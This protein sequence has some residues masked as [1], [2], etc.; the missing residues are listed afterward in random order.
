MD[1]S[2]FLSGFYSGSLPETF[3][4]L[5]GIKL[6]LLALAGIIAVYVLPKLPYWFDEKIDKI[7]VLDFD[8]NTKK[9]FS[10]IL[11]WGVYLAV[12]YLAFYIVGFTLIHRNPLFQLVLLF[13]GIKMAIAALKPSIKK[14]DKKINDVDVKKGSI[15]TKMLTISIYVIGLFIALSIFGLDGAITTALAGAGVIGLVIG[16]GAKD[17]V[18]NTLSGIFIAIDKPFQIGDMIEIKGEV[19]EVTDMGLRTTEIKKF[20]NKVVTIPNSSVA[21]NPVLNYTAEETRRVSLEVGIGYDSDMEEAISTIKTALSSLES[22]AS[23]QEP[24]VL[25]KEFG[26]SAIVME[27]RVW[28]NQEDY[29]VIT[30]TSKAKEAVLDALRE[31]EIN[32]PFPTRV[33]IKR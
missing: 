24:D 7:I 18:S 33:I 10:K 27:G 4:V 26:D 11:E 8:E 28:L 20:D 3:T 30:Q 22:T 29:N 9:E 31:K 16:F 21:N 17:L 23:D 25:M 12:L 19:G 14:V 15:L 1:S 32:V 6:G 13:F 5:T 2:I